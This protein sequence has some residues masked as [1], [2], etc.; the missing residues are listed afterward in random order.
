MTQYII[1]AFIKDGEFA[2]KWIEIKGYMSVIGFEKWSWFHNKFPENSL[3]WTKDKL[4]QVG[5]L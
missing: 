2:N 3:L 1:D 4:Q 5:V